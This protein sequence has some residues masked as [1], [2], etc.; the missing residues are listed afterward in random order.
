MKETSMKKA[1]DRE[2]RG[3]NVQQVYFIPVKG[4][5]QVQNLLP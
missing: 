1:A 5:R 3:K 2:A 4:M